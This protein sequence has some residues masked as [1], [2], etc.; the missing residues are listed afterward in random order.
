VPKTENLDI[1]GVLVDA[2]KHN[3]GRVNDLANASTAWNEGANIREPS[4]ELNVIEDLVSKAFGD[5]RKT[6]PRVFDDLGEI[7]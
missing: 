7:G 4:Q 5:A 2:I 3:K 1:V 6:S